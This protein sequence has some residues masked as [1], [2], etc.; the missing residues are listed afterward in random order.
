MK[1]GAI[2]DPDS[3]MVSFLPFYKIIETIL[4]QMHT[5]YDSS[6][7]SVIFTDYNHLYKLILKWKETVPNITMT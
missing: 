6:G 1:G 2:V 3:G 5:D 4:T 7:S